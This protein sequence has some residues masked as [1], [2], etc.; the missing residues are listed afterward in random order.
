MSP[1]AIVRWRR[2]GV[3]HDRGIR[4]TDPAEAEEFARD[5]NAA[6]DGYEHIV[7]Q[8]EPS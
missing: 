7:S 3:G 6:G 5:M 8:E 1:T 4:F 2:D